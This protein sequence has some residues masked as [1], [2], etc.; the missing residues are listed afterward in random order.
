M[1]GVNI[2]VYAFVNF[3][4]DIGGQLHVPA[5]LPPVNNPEPIE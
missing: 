1:E 5:T 2:I 4:L 3:A